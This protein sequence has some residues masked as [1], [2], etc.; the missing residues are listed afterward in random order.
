MLD[1]LEYPDDEIIAFLSHQHDLRVAQL[2]FLPLGFDPNAAAYRITT[3]DQVSY[4]VKFKRGSFDET[5]LLIPHFLHEQQIE[6]VIAPVSTRN[7]Q[8]TTQ[9]YEFY[10]MVYPYVIGK[11][12]FAVE[13]SPHNWRQLGTALKGI[14]NASLPVALRQKLRQE[15][16]TAYWR[17]VVRSYQAGI[18]NTGT[19]DALARL[20]QH[21]R[22]EIDD[23]VGQAQELGDALAAHPP[24]VVL[25]HADIHGGNVL[26]DE[27]GELFIVDWDDTLLAPKE[28]DLMFVGA[29]IGLG[30]DREADARG[31]WEGYGPAIINSA[32]LVYYRYERIVQDI[33]VTIIEWTTGQHS[34]DN[35]A[36]QI[37]ALEGQFDPGNVV[38][39]ARRTADSMGFKRQA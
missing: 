31:F 23:L 15:S 22:A 20:V 14:H 38:E 10:V 27:A 24:E 7:G 19:T 25:C 5:T 34:D 32:A 11:D 6:S 8:L 30:W 29:G 28:R 36:I 26:I 21:R 33:A 17:D 39:I 37:S 9:F 3:T 2:T 12:G 1:R 4:F 13:L 18:A 35:R 16:Y